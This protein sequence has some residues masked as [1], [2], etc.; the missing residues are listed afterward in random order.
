[1]TASCCF[2]NGSTIVYFDLVFVTEEEKNR[3]KAG[4]EWNLGLEAK[5][6]IQEDLNK[7]FLFTFPVKLQFFPDGKFSAKWSSHC[8]ELQ[9][10]E[11][12]FTNCN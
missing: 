11:H 3:E 8:S 4:I 5:H 9:C 10:S 2:S 7:G 1:M 12:A 6:I